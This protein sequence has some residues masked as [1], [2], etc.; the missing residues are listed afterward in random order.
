LPVCIVGALGKLGKYMVN[1]AL[2]RGH[3]VVAVCREKSVNKLD[4]FKGRISNRRESQHESPNLVL[5]QAS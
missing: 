1:H 3:E 4:E 2:L 5:R